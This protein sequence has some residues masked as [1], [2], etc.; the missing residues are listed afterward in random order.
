MLAGGRP[1]YTLAKDCCFRDVNSLVEDLQRLQQQ[2]SQCE[3][4]YELAIKNENHAL[5]EV[6]RLRGECDKLSAELN[7][8]KDVALSVESEANLSLEALHKRNT[9]LK[10]KLN[11]SKKRIEELETQIGLAGGNGAKDLKAANIQIQF[12]QEQMKMVT[13]KGK[14][15]IFT[16]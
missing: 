9:A 1:V 7:D 6:S 11:E 15:P 16:N 10:L 12:L 14:V 4:N 5:Q 8:I 2:K 3:A 13:E